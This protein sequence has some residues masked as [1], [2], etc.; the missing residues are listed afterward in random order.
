[1]WRRAFVPLSGAQ[2]EVK[3]CSSQAEQVPLFPAISTFQVWIVLSL[4]QV[5]ISTKIVQ[6][7]NYSWVWLICAKP[8]EKTNH[9]AELI[10]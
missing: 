3:S 9:A 10:V 2:Q 6:L 1:M 5:V 8:V 4:D 7:N